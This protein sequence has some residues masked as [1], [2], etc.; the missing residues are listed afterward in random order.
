MRNDRNRDLGGASD[1]LGLVYP[2]TAE[3]NALV[4]KALMRAAENWRRKGRSTYYRR[5]M[6]YEQACVM[7]GVLEEHETSEEYRRFAHWQANNPGRATKFTEKR[8]EAP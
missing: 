4:R 1:T 3:E 2:L 8:E 7:A 6:Y 5:Q